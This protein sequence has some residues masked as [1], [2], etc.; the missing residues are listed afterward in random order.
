M[1]TICRLTVG[2]ASV[3]SLYHS[4]SCLAA[5]I[6]TRAF[7]TRLT[8]KFW[9]G[10]APRVEP[11]PKVASAPRLHQRGAAGLLGVEPAAP[12]TFLCGRAVVGG[13]FLPNKTQFC[14]SLLLGVRGFSSNNQV[15]FQQQPFLWQAVLG[16]SGSCCNRSHEE[17]ATEKPYRNIVRTHR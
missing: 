3:A 12:R 5:A 9:P 8:Q 6:G 13:V 7:C 4:R 1:A 14:N 11:H 17:P 10:R 2:S 16:G 15:V